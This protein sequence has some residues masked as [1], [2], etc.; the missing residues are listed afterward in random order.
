VNRRTTGDIRFMQKR[1]DTPQASGNFG[2]LF[3]MTMACFLPAFAATALNVSAPTIGIEFHVSTSAL[4]W[5]V[6]TFILCSMSLVLPLGRLGDLTSRR[7]L[8]ITGFFILTLTSVLLIFSTSFEM[9]IACRVL[10]GISGACIFATNQAILPD[11]FP[12]SMRGRVLG[13]TVAAVYAG[14]ATGPVIGGLLTHHFGWRSIF[15]FIAAWSVVTAGTS[16]LKLPPNSQKVKYSSLVRTIDLPGSAIY[17]LAV[18]SFAYGINNIF[19][20]HGWVF[21]SVGA[22]LIAGFIFFEGRTAKPLLKPSIFKHNPNFL[23]PCLSAFLNYAAT[24]ALSYLI[25]IYLQQV[26][27]LGPDAA[28]QILV[29]APIVQVI[30]S[31]FAGRLSDRVSPYKLASLGMGISMVVLFSFIFITENTPLVQIFISLGVIGA[32]FGLFSSPN[33]NAILSTV[34]KSDYGLGVSFT[35]TMRNAGQLVSMLIVNIA[36]S[37]NIGQTSMADTGSAEIFLIMH[38]CFIIFTV[39]CFIGMFTSLYRR[40]YSK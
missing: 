26:L 9:I 8:M 23:L 17:L 31:I 15:V 22:A 30:V 2:V 38:T 10:Q 13:I 40:K 7:A 33:T 27:M 36:V 5:L 19:A 14:G 21:A 4:G 12:P 34:S 3:T 29:A 25:S 24:F 39:L 20:I 35:V 11:T 6:T 28:G 18:I 16:L 1:N 32:G 37:L